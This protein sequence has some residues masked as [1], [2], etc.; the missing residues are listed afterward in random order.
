VK[1]VVKAR[2]VKPARSLSSR[3]KAKAPSAAFEIAKLAVTALEAKQGLNPVIT[4]VRDFSTVTDYFVVV[5]GF[6]I[7]HLRALFDEVQMTLKKKGLQC[8][9][10]AE[11]PESG[12]LVL[13]YVDVVIHVLLDE[14][15]KYYAIEDLWAEHR[16][17]R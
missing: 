16:R 10:K 2:A 12:W 7:P 13:D 1:K 5:S 15:R 17:T 3:P 11:D 6:N 14:R 4:D 8:Y 9:R